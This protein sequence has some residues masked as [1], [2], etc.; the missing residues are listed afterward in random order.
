[1]NGT[2]ASLAKL[3]VDTCQL[4]IEGARSGVSKQTPGFPDL[5]FVH[6][7]VIVIDVRITGGAGPAILRFHDPRFQQSTIRG[8]SV[9]TRLTPSNRKSPPSASDE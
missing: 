8:I 1:M 3:S 2:L 5:R 4:A 9:S 7:R 6:P